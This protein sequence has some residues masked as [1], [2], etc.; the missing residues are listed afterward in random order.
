M[1]GADRYVTIQESDFPKLMRRVNQ[2]TNIPVTDEGYRYS[3][4]K[5]TH[6]LISVFRHFD[7]VFM[8][9]LEIL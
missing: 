2:M 5:A 8:A 3:G 7:D 4:G 9:V 1:Q 6:N